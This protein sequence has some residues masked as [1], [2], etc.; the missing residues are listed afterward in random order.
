MRA[1]C[2]D[3]TTTSPQMIVNNG[4]GELFQNEPRFEHKEM[5]HSTHPTLN[6]SPKN[7]AVL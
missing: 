5:L 1:T 3:L 6:T 7:G 2:N 4:C